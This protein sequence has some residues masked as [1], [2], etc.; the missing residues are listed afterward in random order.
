MP[1][2]GIAA[3]QSGLKSRFLEGLAQRDLETIRAAQQSGATMP[4]PSSQTKVTL[5]NIC[6]C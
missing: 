4:V 1:A 5:Q 6:S 3:M 2:S